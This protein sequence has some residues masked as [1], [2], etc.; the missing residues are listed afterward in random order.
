M[1]TESLRQLAR[2]MPK[3][4]FVASFQNRFLVVEYAT[5]Q[6][7]GFDFDTQFGDEPP[8]TGKADRALEVLE[9]VKARNNPYS[10]R[11]SVG[12]ARNCDLVLRDPS[13]SKLHA[14]LREAG[15]Q[16]QIVDLESQNGTKVNGAAVAPNTPV[17]IQIGDQLTFGNVSA[18]LCDAAVLHELLRA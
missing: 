13:V 10:D 11:I 12:R 8:T 3:E 6:R 17:P 18:R 5:G 1:D 2:S 16:Q 15:G 4:R 14:H 7:D 9:V